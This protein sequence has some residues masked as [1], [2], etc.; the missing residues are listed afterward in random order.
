MVLFA[1]ET[2]LFLSG[3][4]CDNSFDTCNVEVSNIHRWFIL[5]KLTINKAKTHY[6]VFQNA[7]RKLA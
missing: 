6:V 5:N 7:D 4:S 2:N 1:D 3:D